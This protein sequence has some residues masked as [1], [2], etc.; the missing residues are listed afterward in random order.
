[1]LTGECLVINKKPKN[2]TNAGREILKK[3]NRN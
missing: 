2:E 3:A 1:M